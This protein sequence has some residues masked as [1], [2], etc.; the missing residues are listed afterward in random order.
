MR[1]QG[2][3][4]LGL[5]VATGIVGRGLAQTPEVPAADAAPA[6]VW[7]D[8]GPQLLPPVT[9]P[10]APAAPVAE[11]PAL[12]ASLPEPAPAAQP[13]SL[14]EITPA[15][16]LPQANPV[17]AELT[18]PVPLPA[19]VPPAA[20]TVTL[21]EAVP[22]T[23]GAETM[24]AALAV[25][26]LPEAL[27]LAEGPGTPVPVADAPVAPIAEVPAAPAAPAPVAEAPAPAAPVA[28]APA[29][30]AAA[31]TAPVAET[32]APAPVAE[33]PAVPVAIVE[34]PVAE[35][36]PAPAPQAAAATP[37]PLPELP[38]LPALELT[39]SPVT[40][41]PLPAPAAPTK[42]A[43]NPF[44]QLREA[45][46]L[47]GLHRYEE[48]ELIARRLL[49]MQVSWAPMNDSPRKLLED[50][51][52]ARVHAKQDGASMVV[53]EGR[54]ALQQ[55]DLEEAE[56]L[57][58]VAELIHGPQRWFAP[59]D[60]PSKLLADIRAARGDRPASSSPV[61][62]TGAPL[63]PVASQPQRTGLVNRIAARFSTPSASPTAA[64]VLMPAPGMDMM[65][66]E[67]VVKTRSL[68]RLNNLKDRIASFAHGPRPTG[69]EAVPMQMIVTPGMEAVPVQVQVVAAPSMA[70]KTLQVVVAPA[71]PPPSQLAQQPDVNPV[72]QTSAVAPEAPPASPPTPEVLP[73]AP[74]VAATE[75]PPVAQPIDA[76]PPVPLGET[77]DPQFLQAPHMADVSTPMPVS[78]P[79]ADAPPPAVP[80]PAMPMP[81]AGVA[82]VMAGECDGCVTSGKSL[83]FCLAGHV[84]YALM[85]PYWKNNPA[86]FAAV[87]GMGREVEFG[88][89]TQFVPE[90]SIGLIGTNNLGF[91][92]NWWGF[93][94]SDAQFVSGPSI[95][96]TAAPLGLGLTTGA[97]G[98]ALAA[99]A[100]LRMNVWDLE[101]TRDYCGD[102]W[103]V[104]VAGGLRYTH[105][106]QR[107]DANL[108]LPGGAV[109]L[110]RSGHSFNGVGPTFFARGRRGLGL[111]LYL[112]GEGRASLL[113]GRAIQDATT[114][115]AGGDVLNGA[116]TGRMVMPVG[117]V[118]GGIGWRR[119][120][121]GMEV[122][123]ETGLVGQVWVEAGNSS[124]SGGVTT[125]DVG[126]VGASS[127][128]DHNLGLLGFT[129][130]VGLNY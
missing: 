61:V 115:D 116:V 101:V 65:P 127:I 72:I 9:E 111:G 71:T 98:S 36:T 83:P 32:P 113:F 43:G 92:T 88:L 94:T 16:A 40:H 8:G 91:R 105:I 89:G 102:S 34:T 49:P 74:T 75:P 99:W 64:P 130:R 124:R 70:P 63:P 46:E 17:A 45:R 41:L 117:E 82:P 66:G 10:A 14:P 1:K 119:D 30:V 52:R 126:G 67:P 39:P 53:A 22:V 62:A 103:A 107:Y 90:L 110:L 5:C 114:L 38:T 48:A 47:Y 123:A 80:M 129:M 44:S 6:P 81:P 27:P 85:R 128:A 50:V 95:L 31:P 106:N 120:F 37:L 23:P 2:K 42:V 118:A 21:P 109:E 60:S 96:A 125:L 76:P 112:Y 69:G 79:A 97:T 35:T 121:D 25:P 4:L 19:E 58:Q 28:E 84:G 104:L 54:R 15:P 7:P 13:S 78:A 3:W 18:L 33:A 68:P 26:R 87:P 93:A 57:A 12:P 56:R 51:G 11:T 77:A 122:F 108:S 29:P 24:D 55:G 86:A 59:D 20:S 73:N 100:N